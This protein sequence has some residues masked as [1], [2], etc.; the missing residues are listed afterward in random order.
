MGI[1]FENLVVKADGA[2][3]T[4]RTEVDLMCRLALVKWLQKNSSADIKDLYEL[5]FREQG[6]DIDYDEHQ[7][8][9]DFTT[10]QIRELINLLQ[11]VTVCDP[12]AGSG[13]FEVG[14][15]QVLNEIL[16]LSL[17]HI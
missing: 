8:Q 16:D 2:V 14:M 6:Q 11:N 17:I 3:Y 12:A 5:F 7:K 13:A 1:I 15:M 4:P 10:A 9:G